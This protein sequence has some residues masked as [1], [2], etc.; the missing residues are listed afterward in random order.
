MAILTVLVE[1]AGETIPQDHIIERVWPDTNV[2]DAN[3][4]VHLVAIRKAL[5]EGRDDASRY[6]LNVPGHGYRFVATVEKRAAVIAS[7]PGSPGLPAILTPLVG[8]DEHIAAVVAALE[9]NRLVSVIGPGGMGKT[10]VALVTAH[11]VAA[12]Y[13]HGAWFV[14][15]TPI[16]D[17][18]LVPTAVAAA[19][20]VPAMSTISTAA[21]ASYLADK[22]SL[23]V[24]DNCEHVIGAVAAHVEALLRAAP[25]LRALVTSREPLRAEGEAIY[26]LPPLDAPADAAA[27]TSAQALEYPAVRLF[28]ERARSTLD[29]F[30]LSDADATTVAQLC[31]TLG[32]VPLAIEL[33][34]ARVDAVGIG[35]MSAKLGDLLSLLTRGR[36][37]ASPR[38]QTL[39][40]TLDW[41]FELLPAR[42]QSVFARLGVFRSRFALDAALAVVA[43]DAIAPREIAEAL[44]SLAAK[45]LVVATF[46]R[47]AGAYRLLETTREYALEKLDAGNDARAT[48]LRHGAYLRSTW[49]AL[50]MTRRPTDTSQLE[51][52]AHLIDDVRAALDW[53]FSP[54]GDPD[55]ALEL[56]AASAPLWFHL[57]LVDE[58]ASRADR[59]LS[60]RERSR[61]DAAEL[62]VLVALG[63]A[64]YNTHG[65]VPGALAAYDR[66]LEVAGRL[67]DA[68]GRRRALFGTW[69]YHLNRGD[70]AIA[71]T[72]VEVFERFAA[73][74]GDPEFLGP[75]MA[76][77]VRTY[78]G[79]LAGAS[80]L[81]DEVLQR[82]PVRTTRGYA[83][84]EYDPRVMAQAM[85]ARVRWLEGYPDQAARLARASLDEAL[86]LD[87]AMSICVAAALGACPVALWSGDREAAAGALDILVERSTSSRL[88]QWH[89]Y[90]QVY[91]H[92]I[93]SRGGPARID[94]VARSSW[95][96]RQREEL[97]VVVDGV[98]DPGLVERARSGEPTWCAAEIV[99]REAVRV[100]ADDDALGR[101]LLARSLELARA[102]GCPAWELRT[103]TSLAGVATTA[104]ERRE[105]SA[106]LEAIMARYTEGT[107]TADVRA[108]SAQLA[109]L[110]P[111]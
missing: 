41:S 12:R 71:L 58:Y 37:T 50:G 97:F 21:V 29:S 63:S 94:P 14:D 22:R 27:I 9:R 90:S 52:H 17:P 20:R 103:A 61:N 60:A 93:E 85:L 32:G 104:A 8:R 108:A 34:A 45:S 26:R 46:E 65:S 86:A 47:G 38:H 33:A 40:A 57:S 95:S 56:V 88:R 39:R 66:A 2:D 59:A 78:R 53:A 70:Y 10:S 102:Q 68:D 13:D 79:E 25:G 72:I 31:S 16:A 92:A 62:K 54:D 5:R 42:E 82:H 43:D 83:G 24:L 77:I 105:A 23:V 18:A 7:D 15:L 35:M 109:V 4:R 101:E 64:L 6:I 36:R 11:A 100:L 81:I 76:L 99:R 73:T 49:T 98:V 48:R 51:H 67:D 96:H 75:R 44:T 80:A 87:H 3:L 28:V 84:L 107:A 30:E 74:A 1:R 55:A 111:A 89:R 69:Q 19:L 106:R 91:A 110:Y